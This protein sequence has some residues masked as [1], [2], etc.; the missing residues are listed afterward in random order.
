MIIVN[1]FFNYAFILLIAFTAGCYPYAKIESVDTKVIPFDTTYSKSDEDSEINDLVLPY[2]LKKDSVM[3]SELGTTDVAMVKGLPEGLLGDFVSDLVL[4]E[5]R[6]HYNPK[7]GHQVDICLLNNGGL[8]TSL[9]KGIITREKA[10]ELMPFDNMMVVLT[11]SGEETKA[12]FDFV[13]RM[14]GMPMAGARIGVKDSVAANIE[15]GG[16]PFDINKSYK[17]TTSDYLSNGGDKMLFFK[18]PLET[19]VLGILLRDA[20]IEYMTN[21]TK[22]GRMLSA[23]LDGRIYKAN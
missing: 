10:F 2:I 14:G 16:K 17:V 7:D 20:I 15:I 11:L 21:E 5:A 22:Q 12:L 6:L 23:K 13:A 18:N 9:P 1:R 19:E 3:H 4:K 8:R